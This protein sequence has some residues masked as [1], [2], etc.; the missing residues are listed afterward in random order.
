MANHD[1]MSSGK[2][3]SI[4]DQEIKRLGELS[5]RSTDDENKLNALKRV[6][7][8]EAAKE[9]LENRKEIENIL[10]EQRKKD[11]I[12]E[13]DIWGAISEDVGNKFKDKLDDAL[14]SLSSGEATKKLTSQLDTI[15]NNYIDAQEK[16]SAH[17]VGV[18]GGLQGAIGNLNQALSSTNLVKQQDV[19]N[20]LSD[21]VSRG[22]VYNVE[23]RAFLQTLSSDLDMTFNAAD[24][25]LTQLIRL[26]QHDLSANR[27]A[28]EYSLQ[29][30]LNQN[31]KT[32]E[33]IK[34]AM[35]D[36][37]NALL[38]MQSLVDANQ[39]VAL[40]TDIQAWLGAY[41]S[42]GMNQ[43]TVTGLAQAINALGSG[44]ITNLGSG[45]SNL[46]LMG[47]AR[48]NLDYGELLTN[49]L[50]S[51]KVDSLMTGITGYLREIGDYDNNV[52]ISQ[53]A[54]LFGVGVADITAANNV[55]AI[56]A[57]SDVTGL[58]DDVG[59]L[60]PFQKWISNSLS[61]A[62]FTWGTSVASSQGKYIAYEIEKLIANSGIGDLLV[63]EGETLG[64]LKGLVTT[65]AGLAI[66]NAPL[67]S[68]FTSGAFTDILSGL[69]GASGINSSLRGVFNLLGGY[70][71]GGYT[72]RVSDAGVSGM[73]YISSTDY[74]DL[75]NG[76]NTSMS[77]FS[78]T[79]NI[80]DDLSK[81]EPIDLIQ[82]DV[83]SILSVLNEYMGT[84]SS[85]IDKISSSIGS[86]DVS[87]SYS[88]VFGG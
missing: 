7:S 54:K 4:L 83:A 58:L 46:V 52:V 31:Y 77:D 29:E 28:I 13:G 48:A 2:N 3:S 34:S 67:L 10:H 5:S 15:I 26:Q 20:K 76:S 11:L 62:M 56:G 74:Q 33:Y 66:S 9:E 25:T 8:Q 57:L 18:D 32:S 87:G 79:L 59:S 14:D 22:I 81:A 53:L 80:E 44:D 23:Q 68:L 70:D 71:V 72:T 24:G 61:N 84:I 60:V 51:D 69:S 17:L 55:G 36:V 85:N 64:G 82:S 1:F 65:T 86:S 50:T 41:Y 45:L 49:G 63:T 6:H 43:S 35:T 12:A 37:S 88:N 19:Y 78:Q 40:E 30:F 73:M 42:S 47:A 16:L 38:D 39:A 27:I 75:L 21:L